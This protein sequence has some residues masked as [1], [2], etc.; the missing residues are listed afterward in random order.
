MTTDAQVRIDFNA[1]ERRMIFIRNPE[2]ASLDRA[3]FDTCGR[4]GTAG[5][6]IRSDR[7]DARLLFTRC[8]AVADRHGPVLL[9]HVEDVFFLEYCH[10]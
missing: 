6:A 10:A 4:A 3:V 8:F 5:A 1:S 9:D 7:Q 2:H